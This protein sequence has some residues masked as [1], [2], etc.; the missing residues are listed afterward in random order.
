VTTT[1]LL[2]VIP[3]SLQAKSCEKIDPNFMPHKSLW[4][5]NR[6]GRKKEEKIK[7]ASTCAV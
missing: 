3:S 4:K 7:N 6:R 5:L 2:G 1:L